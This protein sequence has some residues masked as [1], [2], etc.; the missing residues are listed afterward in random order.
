MQLFFVATHSSHTIKAK[1]QLLSAKNR[2]LSW[3]L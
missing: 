1:L 3:Q 2:R